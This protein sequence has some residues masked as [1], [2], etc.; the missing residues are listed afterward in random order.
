MNADLIYLAKLRYAKHYLMVLE[1][2][3]AQYQQGNSTRALTLLD[4]EWANI[5]NARQWCLTGKTDDQQRAKLCSAFSLKPAQI[6]ELRLSPQQIITWNRQALSAARI[7]NDRFAWGE[8]LGHI[9]NALLYQGHAKRAIRLYKKNLAI[10]QSFNQAEN[11]AYILCSLGHAYSDTNQLPQAIEV[12]K[13]AIALGRKINNTLALSTALSNLGCVY[14]QQDQYDQA[15]HCFEQDLALSQQTGDLHGEGI[16]HTNLGAVLADKLGPQAALPHHQQALAIARQLNDHNSEVATLSAIARCQRDSEQ[17]E[18]SLETCQQALDMAST[19]GYQRAQSDIFHIM[20]DCCR[21]QQHWPQAHKYYLQVLEASEGIDH[22]EERA[23]ALY[24]LADVA[25][26]QGLWQ[27]AREFCQQGLAICERYPR[28]CGFDP[29]HLDL[30]FIRFEITLHDNTNADV[31]NDEDGLASATAA[32]ELAEYLQDEKACNKARHLLAQW[33]QQSPI[34]TLINQSKNYARLCSTFQLMTASGEQTISIDDGLYVQREIEQQLHEHITKQINDDQATAYL[35]VLNGDAGLGKTSIL[36]RLYRQLSQ[37]FGEP[38]VWLMRASLL[39]DNEFYQ[40]TLTILNSVKRKVIILIDTVDLLLQSDKQSLATVEK[41]LALKHVGGI[42]I[43]TSRVREYENQLRPIYKELADTPNSLIAFKLSAYSDNELHRAISSHVSC[44]YKALAAEQSVQTH[45]DKICSVMHQGTPLTEIC[46]NPL[47][48]RMLFSVYAPQQVNHQEVNTFKLFD[49]FWAF[50]VIG[51]CRLFDNNNQNKPHAD[52]TTNNEVDT[53]NLVKQIALTMTAMGTTEID[54]A[55]LVEWNNEQLQLLVNRGVLV[56][57]SPTVVSFFHQTFFEHAAGRGLAELS[58]GLAAM[59]NK[60]LAEPDNLYLLPVFEQTVLLS[61]KQPGKG[62]LAA[63]NAIE[64]ICANNALTLVSA[65]SYIFVH[66]TVVKNSQLKIIID[67]IILPGSESTQCSFITLL[68]NVPGSRLA[69]AYQVLSLLWQQGN[70]RVQENICEL[71]FKLS[72]RNIT[73]FAEFFNHNQIRDVL[74]SKNIDKSL[75][76]KRL[77]ILADCYGVLIEHQ[78]QRAF[79]GLMYCFERIR[80]MVA[81]AHVLVKI[82]RIVEHNL[83]TIGLQTIEETLIPIILTHQYPDNFR[84][85]GFSYQTAAGQ[86]MFCLWQAF[87][88]TMS[89][90]YQRFTSI[91][92]RVE[93]KTKNKAEHKITQLIIYN[94]LD[95]FVL[96]KPEELL[97]QLFD[98]I[99]S[100]QSV[101]KRFLLWSISLSKVARQVY[102]TPKLKQQFWPDIVEFTT[103]QFCSNDLTVQKQVMSFIHF[104]PL[105]QQSEFIDCFN[106]LTLEQWSQES[107]FKLAVIAAA[108]GCDNALRSIKSHQTEKDYNHSLMSQFR[109]YGSE[110]EQIFSLLLNIMGEDI[111]LLTSCYRLLTEN[112]ITID[113]QQLLI[114]H[115]SQLNL[116]LNITADMSVELIQCKLNLLSFLLPIAELK[117][118]QPALQLLTQRFNKVKNIPLKVA[119]AR[120]WLTYSHCREPL[121]THQT[122][123]DLLALPQDKKVK[124]Q[125]IELASYCQ[126]DGQTKDEQAGK[127]DFCQTVE[128]ILT[129]IAKAGTDQV[130]IDDAGAM[131]NL[132]EVMLNNYGAGITANYFTRFVRIYADKFGIKQKKNVTHKLLTISSKICVGLTQPQ[133]HDFIAVAREL[134]RFTGRVLV[135]AACKTRLR[136]AKTTILPFIE[137]PE[138]AD[139]LKEM[140]RKYVHHHHR[141]DWSANWLELH[142][143]LG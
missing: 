38:F 14:H 36:A 2:A 42:V 45:I 17:W 7:A 101:N 82:L 81:G 119:I 72:V 129:N 122:L 15:Q 109:Q 123:R 103:T 138:L 18:L 139:E 8:H 99:Q 41:L 112:T 142:E 94:A 39:V 48:L 40:Q 95:H 22:D 124:L 23:I 96:A 113:Y 52:E 44:F 134:D 31:N 60:V 5:T 16:A 107:L 105:E 127:R 24:N 1:Q 116:S 130:N 79:D 61:V 111:G 35:T 37:Q 30:C 54:K 87:N 131:R 86:L 126:T 51:D 46:R 47:T 104:L 56:Y 67:Q 10:A 108:N 141:S 13:Q 29:V 55:T 78:P 118:T 68:A 75:G 106:A 3:D 4:Q 74:D 120:Y 143:L 26:S 12:L 70:W 121:I 43:C 53:S 20:G 66:S 28:N 100:E 49:D 115:Q 92:N 117:L 135:D 21:L 63:A 128:M 33:R 91:E 71:V 76:A 140:I 89:D 19:M 77:S 84:I 98:F 62:F 97:P 69:E 58:G 136:D 80:Q 34:Q 57:P 73:L 32:L 9:A 59:T 93:N 50:R 11:V 6:L 137:D 25:H 110:N 125:L 102:Q 27:Q 85:K 83:S 64:R 65:A 114:A 132:F 133:L 90:F 88:R